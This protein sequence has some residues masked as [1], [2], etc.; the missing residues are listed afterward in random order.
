[1]KLETIM[2]TFSSLPLTLNLAV[3][4]KKKEKNNIFLLYNQLTLIYAVNIG[5]KRNET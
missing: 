5:M 4:Q 1:M 3:S 2:M